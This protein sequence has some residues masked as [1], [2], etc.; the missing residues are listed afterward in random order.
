MKNLFLLV[1][2]LSGTFL[3]VSAKTFYVAANGNNANSGLSAAA[4]WQT[5][6]KVNASFGS[7]VAGDSIVFRRGDTFLGALVIG[8]SGSSGKPIVIS[9]YGTGAK[10]IITGFVNITSWSSM[11]NG[12]YQAYVPAA[13]I[14][15]NM[16]TLNNVPQ[17]LGRYPNPTEGN[18]GYLSYESFAGST[19]ITDNQ[20]TSATN[21]TGA[22]V[23]VRKKLWV[24]D[25][26]KV[27][28][29]SGTK[30]TFTNTNGSTYEGTNGYGYFFQN[31]TR[32]LDRPGEWCF[33]STKYLQMFFG[34]A[35][36]SAYNVK[37]STI[38]TLLIM[39]S[40]SFININ[41]IVFEG[42]N[43]TAISGISGGNINIQQCDFNG[44]GVGAISMQ[45]ISNLL[46]ENCTTSNILNTAIYV[47]SS[48]VSN[49]TIRGCSVNK[50]GT[51]PGMGLSNGNSYKGILATALSNLVIEYNNVDTTGYVG[52]EFQGSNVN[53]RNNV[54]N[55]FD[56]VKD[57]AGG[58]YTYTAGTD[59][60]PGTIY[61]NRTI[62]NNIVM[63][64]I[65]APQGRNAT[66]LFVSGIYLDGRS[67][68]VSI[69]NNTVFNH[70][71]NGIHLNN[72]TGITV[73]GNT[74]Y[75]NLNNMSAMRWVGNTIQNLII[76]NNIFYTKTETQRGFYYTNSGINQPSAT[77]LSTALSNL[78]SIDSN[79]YSTINPTPFNFE[80]YATS[81]G[82]FIQSSPL[83][84]EGWQ[85]YASKDPN[86]KKPAKLPVTHKVTALIGGN[87]FSNGLFNTGISGITLFGTSVLSGWDNTGKI[88]GGSLKVSFSNPMANKYALFH[89]PIG[90][91]SAAKKY[92]LRLSTFGTTQQGIVRA[93]IRKST[94]PY[95]NLVSTQ[96]KTFGVGRSDHEFLFTAPETQAGGSFV[97]EIEQNSGTT[98]ID[99][100]QF[101]E[102]TATVYDAESQLRFEYNAT[103]TAKTIALDAKYIAVDG[104]AYSGSLTLQPFTSVILVKDTGT[105]TTPPPATALRAAANAAAANCYGG[106]AA[107]AITASG[108]TAPYTGAGNFTAGA[109]NGSLR[110]TFPSA[111]VG[112]YTMLYYTIGAVS[113]AKTYVLRFTTLGTTNAGKLRASIRQTTTPWAVITAKQTGTYGTQRKDHE[114][115]FTAPP[116][117][118]AASF[119]IEI[120]Q[121]SGTTYVDNVAFFEADADGTLRGNNLYPA[122]QFEATTNTLFIYSSNNNHT[123]VWDKTSKIAATHYYTVK[124]AVNSTA[125]ASV[126]VT[127]P[128]EPLAV[129]VSVG[130][131]S[132]LGGRATV[133]VSA[134]GGTA[135]YTGTGSFSLLAGSYTYSITDSKGCTAATTVTVLPFGTSSRPSSSTT[136]GKAT[137]SSLTTARVAA[138]PAVGNT[139]NGALRLNA[140]PNPS[141]NAFN[142]LV[143]GGSAERVMLAVYS[144]E[145]RMVYQSSGTSNTKYSFGN[146][147]Q[148]GI[149]IL[150]VIQGATTQTL[151]L[152]KAGN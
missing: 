117:Q 124:D 41:N 98:Y 18:G 112:N 87:K 99:N 133:T 28:A 132:V 57:D 139:L 53:V 32:T 142:L 43:G 100:V 69:L 25:R 26:C 148:P 10:P 33:K 7:V 64:G 137:D 5:I 104:T 90:A 110:L 37:A 51:L 70:G 30:L 86:G 105:V 143:E 29:H 17:A 150:K 8:K 144:A 151:K 131:I 141:V 84:L 121:T 72:P 21:W 56:F 80:I 94:S 101:Y 82:S 107:V 59:A 78:G 115:V 116:S 122:G 1:V 109:G 67:M 39:S 24:L 127:Q 119:L 79:T 14:S 114:F 140:Y 19:S 152:V 34:T 44:A 11:G 97:I 27:T 58:I 60:S 89:S 52:I 54:V 108:G 6:S 128:A 120:D 92:V 113:A 102:A 83:S 130:I 149:Y 134:T 68:N 22:E 126:T 71:K 146:N 147:F 9:A 93:Y 75:N 125:V 4:P 42:A 103:K 85:S 23:V 16:V 47:Y 45:A 77:P 81:G 123:A 20:L 40:R 38:D 13:K 46:I 91:V 138:A 65:G 129:S 136:A 76:R 36:P 49:V 135:P 96:V 66:S 61:T 145:G 74:C 88:S 63:N 106:N 12:I 73:R 111:V 35:S 48:K 62:S 50:T 31:D 118:A 2:V 55:Y 95:N 3:N 15:L